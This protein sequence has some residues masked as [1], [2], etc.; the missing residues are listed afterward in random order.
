MTYSC[1]LYLSLS[2][3]SGVPST[4]D[5]A[6]AG[7]I[8]LHTTRISYWPLHR[9]KLLSA[10]RDRARTALTSPSSRADSA[11]VAAITFSASVDL[12]VVEARDMAGVLSLA[13]DA[14]LSHTA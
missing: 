5:F 10:P 3:P 14:T 6:G 12:G 4:T 1:L 11:S 7:I 13:E 8:P 2:D 9:I